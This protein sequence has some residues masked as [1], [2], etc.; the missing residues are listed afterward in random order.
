ML[1]DD[2]KERRHGAAQDGWS[3]NGQKSRCVK[4]GD[5]FRESDGVHVDDSR[6]SRR[7]RSQNVRSSDETPVMGAERRER[8]EGMRNVRTNGTST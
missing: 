5:L 8:R 2:R 7:N 3:R 1:G 4:Q 6:K